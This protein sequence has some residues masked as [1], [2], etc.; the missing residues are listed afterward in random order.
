[1]HCIICVIGQGTEGKS[2]ESGGYLIPAGV[3]VLRSME[4]EIFNLARCL[5]LPT[6]VTRSF[7][8]FPQSLHVNFSML[9]LNRP[10]QPFAKGVRRTSFSY[11]YQT[12][13]NSWN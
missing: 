12:L 5:K 9:S 7:C 8:D 10:Q 4:A 6:V 13:C 3:F 2:F 11:H 1:M